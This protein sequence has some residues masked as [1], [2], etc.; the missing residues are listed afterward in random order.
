MFR[1]CL[2]L[3]CLPCMLLASSQLDIA[4]RWEWIKSQRGGVAGGWITPADIGYSMHMIIR[5][6]SVFTYHN[7]ALAT[8]DSLKSLVHVASGTRFLIYSDTLIIEETLL[9]GVPAS[10][11]RKAMVHPFSGKPPV[12]F[13]CTGLNYAWGYTHKG[14]LIDSS[15]AIRSFA[16]TLAD[17][18]GYVAAIDTLPLKFFQKLLAKSTPTGKTVLS[19]TFLSKLALIEPASRGTVSSSGGCYD[20]GIYRY[21][22]FMARTEA[23]SFKQIICYQI[24]DEEACNSAVAARKIAR[25]LNTI[26]S[27]DIRSCSPPDSCLNYTTPILQKGH[28]PMRTPASPF[29]SDGKLIQVELKQGA[30]VLVRSYSLGGKLLAATDERFLPAGKHRIALNHLLTRIRGKATVIVE[31]SIAG[32]ASSAKTIIISQAR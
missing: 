31:L 17:S 20:F 23:P 10:Y 3:I 25:W 29:T 16:L 2:Q 26:D 12:T 14:L 9:E 13:L 8:S 24:G 30:P 18:L 21:S 22:C 7:D 11:W 15:G 28:S 27:M 32:V 6:D 5:N 19:D 4:G 1:H